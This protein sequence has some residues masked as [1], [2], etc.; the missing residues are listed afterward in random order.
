MKEEN[1]PKVDY[2]QKQVNRTLFQMNNNYTEGGK[3]KN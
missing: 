3:V 1:H 2:T